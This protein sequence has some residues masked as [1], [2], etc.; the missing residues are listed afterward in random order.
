MDNMDTGESKIV[1]QLHYM[2]VFSVS[3]NYFSSLAC[4]EWP[5]HG[6]PVGENQLLNMID[7]MNEFHLD[8]DAPILVHCR[9]V[10]S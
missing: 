4:R 8:K 1:R 9:Y 3:V 5:D 6:C 10:G 7:K 2:L